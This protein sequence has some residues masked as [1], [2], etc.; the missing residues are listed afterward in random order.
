MNWLFQGFRKF[1]LFFSLLLLALASVLSCHGQVQNKND[2][3][4][5][6]RITL[7]FDKDWRFARYNVL[8][9][10]TPDFDDSKWRKIDLPHDWSIE[11]LAGSA[12]PFHPQALSQVSGGFTTGGTGWYLKTFSIA[13]K[14]KNNR[15][16]LQFDG[17]YMNADFWLNG[18]HLGNHPYGYTSFWFDV[19][20][21]IKFGK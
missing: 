21:K 11:D 12:S 10:E 8:M 4:A 20:D 19:T 13:D 9:A 2:L 6:N 16:H 3:S 7:S 15:I 5:S 1:R 14:Q 18:E 17:V